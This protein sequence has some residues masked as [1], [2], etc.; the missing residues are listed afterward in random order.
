MVILLMT[1]FKLTFFMIMKTNDSDF[2]FLFKKN[3][4]QILDH[5]KN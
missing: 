2:F 3:Q 4:R 1:I 5:S